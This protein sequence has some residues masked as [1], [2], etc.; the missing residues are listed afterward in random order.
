M[1]E[2]RRDGSS[3]RGTFSKW[4]PHVA[5]LEPLDDMRIGVGRDF[6][7]PSTT[8][9][10]VFS[11]MPSGG[12]GPPPFE[13]TA[14]TSQ[15]PAKRLFVRDVQGV[16]YQHGV[17]GFG[18][19]IDEVAASLRLVLGEQELKRL[20]VC[21]YSAGGYAALLFGTLLQ[22][23]LVVAFS[24]QTFLDR[25]WLASIGDNRWDQAL[26]VLDG[27]GGP[28][29]RYVDLRAALSR[30]PRSEIRYDVHYDGS[31]PADGQ[32]V[33]RLDGTPGL[34]LYEH[35][36]AGFSLIRSLRVTGDLRRIFRTA[37]QS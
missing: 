37:T 12:A 20:V 34:E 9:L 27:L 21:G 23:D 15:I 31:F 28:D 36:S 2:D 24:P 4:A 33:A 17:P 6:A 22:A 5:T 1:P 13:F 25:G 29:A 10:L 16:W 26:D 19:S 18:R 14:L 11:G 30:E 35:P 3:G 32:H 8:M 7:K